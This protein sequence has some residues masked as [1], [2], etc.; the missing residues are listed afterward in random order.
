MGIINR[1]FLFVFALF[2]VLLSL[3]VLAVCLQIVP[4]HYWLNELRF[5]LGR[6]ETIVAS[7]AAFFL[8]DAASRRL[9]LLHG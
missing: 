9:S 2:L 4:E 3:G 1:F 8:G 5:A 7:A 6:Q